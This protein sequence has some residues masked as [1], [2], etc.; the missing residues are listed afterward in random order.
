MIQRLDLYKK[1]RHAFRYGRIVALL[2]LA[3]QFVSPDSAH[4]FDLE[5]PVSAAKLAEPMNILSGLKGMVVIDE[6]QRQPGLFPL[7]CVLADRKPLPARFRRILD[8]SIYGNAR[9]HF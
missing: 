2:G 4:Y 8:V 3:R 9:E 7:L 5:D 1:I 6:I